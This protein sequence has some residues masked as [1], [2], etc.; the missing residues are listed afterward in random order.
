MPVSVGPRASRLP[1][2]LL[3]IGVVVGLLVLAIGIAIAV[4]GP[5]A[6]GLFVIACVPVGWMLALTQSR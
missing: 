4:A 5:L 3:L 6:I 1:R 2:E